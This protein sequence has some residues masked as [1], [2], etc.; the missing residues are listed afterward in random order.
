V[1]RYLAAG[2]AEVEFVELQGE[3]KT[4]LHNQ[5]L[6][7]MIAGSAGRA[8]R[9][10]LAMT[11]SRARRLGLGRHPVS[12]IEERLVI[13]TTDEVAS[14]QATKIA[15]VPA[16][17]LPGALWPRR[18]L[19]ELRVKHGPGGART[20]QKLS[21]W[22]RIVVAIEPTT[23]ES[24][25]SGIIIA[26]LGRD[27]QG[28][29]LADHS[30]YYTMERWRELAISLFERYRA[31]CIVAGS[32]DSGRLVRSWLA[33]KDPQLPLRLQR[34]GSGSDLAVE[35]VANLYRQSRVHH[36]GAFATLEDQMVTCTGRLAHS[37]QT[38]PG[39][40]AALVW[41]LSELIIRHQPQRA[42]SIRLSRG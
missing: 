17:E 5:A 40:L 31:D 11:W 24:T 27:E 37:A 2:L 41:A 9:E 21:A 20:V 23:S 13:V 16:P 39:R 32:T 8:G 25:E 36:I 15:R 7:S 42:T 30:G 38:L 6:A 33:M 35:L 18:R 1:Q 22:Q 28:Y 34:R 10:T 14:T 3:R 12:E 19:D 29:V 26:A 4:R